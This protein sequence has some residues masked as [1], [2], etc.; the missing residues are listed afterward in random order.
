MITIT[1]TIEECSDYEN[2]AKVKFSS[3]G[4]SSQDGATKLEAMS[5]EVLVIKI[6]KAIKE[7]SQETGGI[8]YSETPATIIRKKISEH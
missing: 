7:V 4:N 8:N 1:T 6:V 3:R 5:A 2:F